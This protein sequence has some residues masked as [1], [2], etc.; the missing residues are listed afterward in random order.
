MVYT[1]IACGFAISAII[2]AAA[3]YHQGAINKTRF[4]SLGRRLL[5]MQEEYDAFI[6]EYDLQ[7]KILVRD[8]DMLHSLGQTVAIAPKVPQSKTRIS[9]EGNEVELTDG[10]PLQGHVLIIGQS[11]SGKSVLVMTQLMRR[12]RGQQEVHC[13][14]TKGEIKPIFGKYVDCVAPEDAG[15]KFTELLAIAKQR[16]KLFSDTTAKFQTPCRDF[17]EYFEITGDKLPIVSLV[18]EELIVL[19]E[20]VDEAKLIE[21]LV[22]GRSAGVFVV[23]LSQYMKAEILS[24]K[25]LVNFGTRV[26]LGQY[27]NVS[28]N[29]IF[30]MDKGTRNQIETF[31]GLPGKAAVQENGKITTRAMP[32]VLKEHLIPF[33]KH[34]V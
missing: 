21:M 25:G 10:L 17:S 12:V 27:D 24:R 32:M 30:N 2:I 31:V 23:A 18:V 1:I 7:I 11:G 5:S 9:V 19:M 29:L 20:M 22:I 13:I 8:V 16:Q 14:D 26:F 6:E 3:S 28:C 4:T 33:I 15:D 34:E